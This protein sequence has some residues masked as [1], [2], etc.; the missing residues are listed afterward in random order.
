[1]SQKLK[2]IPQKI[3]KIAIEL[4]N[5]KNNEP[6]NPDQMYK[7]AIECGLCEKHGYFPNG[8]TPHSSFAAPIYAD[9]K[10][11][12]NSIFE[13]AALKPKKLIRI[14]S[15]NPAE[16]PPHKAAE[17][18]TLFEPTKSAES[19][20]EPNEQVK[21]DL[22]KRILEKEPKFFEKLALDLMRKM[23]YGVDD[24][25]GFSLTQSSRDGGVDGIIS[26]DR[27]GFSKIYIQAKRYDKGQIGRPELQKFVGTIDD[28]PTKKGLFITTA[29]FTKDAAEYAKT[30]QNC[31]IT[32]IDGKR[33]AELLLEYELGVEIKEIK[34]IYKINSD[35]FNDE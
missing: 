33:L 5:L 9:I 32:L 25:D 18:Q 2:K 11:N 31:T 28:K 6:L 30:R 21:R 15:Q 29:T 23:G 4:L 8:K 34:K 10:H 12:P 7:M 27:L 14:K 17:V 3:S 22:I 13:V 24:D 20:F 26:E 16:N 1:M 35:Y 19:V